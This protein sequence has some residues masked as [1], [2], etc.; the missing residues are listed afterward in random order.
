MWRE[1]EN[2]LPARPRRRKHVGMSGELLSTTERA[3]LRRLAQEQSR[4]RVPSLIAALVRDGETIWVD[5]RGAI[6]EERATRDTQYR[7]GSITK[8]FVA[9][10]VI[11]LR[12]EGRLALSDRLG[13]HLPG[14]SADD[15]PLWQLLAHCSGLSSEPNGPWWERAPGSEPERFIPA[16]DHGELRPEPQHVFHYSNTAYGLLGQLVARHRG[17]DFMQVLYEEILAPL[18]MRR[19][20]AQPIEPYAPGW[21]VHP[22][23]DILQPEPSEDAGAM[24]PAG[25]LWS[26]IDD[27]VRWLRF[28][29]GETTD[30]LHPD[31]LVQM[32]QPASVDDGDEW[33]RGFGL[34]LQLVRHNGRRLVGHGG[35][36][37]GFLATVLADPAEATGVVFLANTTS[38]VGPLATDLLDILHEHEPRIPPEWHP[39]VRVAAELLELTG[40]WHWGPVPHLLRVLPDG[41]LDLS[42]W[43]G[44]G[45][46]SRFR[47]DSEGNWVGLDGYH[48]GEPLRVVRAE[49]GTPSHLDLNTFILTR[50]PYDPNAPV[51]GGVRSWQ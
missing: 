23:A 44:P 2:G 8:T 35:S 29:I 50:T 9:V 21:A 37:P 25:Q 42:A 5:T 39:G 7:I 41:K 48:Q 15:R 20:T 51:P 13:D 33:T 3:L 40:L 49:D 18:G 46:S 4:N 31:S 27:M 24:A 22:F 32:R 26:T 47:P 6:R 17:K 34:G 10:L 19:T 28:L 11:R 30:V 38:G 12:D 16:I 36:M 45:R 1:T 43:Y 14:T